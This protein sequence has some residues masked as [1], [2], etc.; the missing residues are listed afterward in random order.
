MRRQRILSQKRP[1]AGGEAR[2]R[3]SFLLSGGSM[4]WYVI[5]KKYINYLPQFDSHVG[6]V[7]YGERLKL[8]VGI[9]LTIGDFHYYVPIS[10]AKHQKMSN[11]LDFHKLQD[12][13]TGYYSFA[14]SF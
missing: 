1:A 13:S 11:S 7:E 8:H 12:E 9:L 5:D 10:S 2:E 6:Y 4:D 14:L 3:A